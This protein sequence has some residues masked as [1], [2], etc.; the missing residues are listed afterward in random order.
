MT[1]SPT[2]QDWLDSLTRFGNKR[3]VGL[4][5]NFGTR[6][7]DFSRLYRAAL[8]AAHLLAECKLQAGD[9]VLLYAPAS[10][11]W[12]ALFLG[13]AWR[14]LV[15][16]TLDSNSSL[17]ELAAIVRCLSVKLVVFTAGQRIEAVDCPLLR[18]QALEPSTDWDSDA[19]RLRVPVGID[20]TATEFAD[21]SATHPDASSSHRDFLEQVLRLGRSIGSSTAVTLVPPS[22]HSTP[23][24][25]AAL[26]CSLQAGAPVMFTRSAAPYHLLRVSRSVRK[27]KLLASSTQLRSIE[28]FVVNRASASSHA[29]RGRVLGSSLRT[30]LICGRPLSESSRQFWERLRIKIVQCG[31]SSALVEKHVDAKPP[32]LEEILRSGDSPVKAMYLA[33]YIQSNVPSAP[34]ADVRQF[35]RSLP[36]DSIEQ[37]EIMALLLS[38]P[39]IDAEAALNAEDGVENRSRRKHRAP[40]WQRL[41]AAAVLRGIAS[42]IFRRLIL[43]V[44]A[45]V[46][47]SGVDR[48]DGLTGPIF[49][50]S[51]RSDRRHPVEFLGVVRALP[52]R[53]ARRVMVGVSDRPFLESHFYRRHG[54]SLPYRLLISWVAMFGLPSVMP[55]S[56]LESALSHGF[57]EICDWTA[58]GYHPLVTWSPAMA[59]LATEVQ[60]TIIPVRLRGRSRGWWN[61]EVFVQFGVPR[62][63]LPF[64]DPGFTYLDV[65]T[66]LHA[67]LPEVAL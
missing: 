33:A 59:L 52:P 6:W 28:N 67:P 61:T 25:I 51:R 55:Y 7:W 32:S 44:V 11:E 27:S 22:T 36:L 54:D 15:P 17:D 66:G 63:I 19:A 13:C 12:I 64:A 37:A 48:L 21:G 35:L 24:W 5:S 31:D 20:D 57:E 50:A 10:P 40:A 58:R 14:G 29:A 53:L 18:I 60:A 16:V 2:L 30:L 56:L 23:V 65:E 39:A 46:R 9:R 47:V 49:F 62:Q 8:Y 45:R 1:E 4:R 38:S 43:R 42:P 26:L 3:A 34:L 41:G